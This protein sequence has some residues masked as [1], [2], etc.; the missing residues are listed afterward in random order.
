MA[1]HGLTCLQRL[2]GASLLVFKNKSDVPGCMSEDDIREVRVHHLPSMRLLRE[3]R[4][5]SSTAFE[6]T[7]GTS[8]RAQP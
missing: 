8:C 3:R 4:D 1:T 6:P 5:Y 7:N 2:M